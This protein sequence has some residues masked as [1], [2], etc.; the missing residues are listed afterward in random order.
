MATQ[1]KE[2]STALSG[3]TNILVEPGKPEVIVSR[4]FDVPRERLF[5]VMNDPKLLPQWWGP[6]YL[7]TTVDKLEAK[8]GGSWR[9][10][11]QGEDG[12]KHAFHG[13]Y[14]TVT[15]PER[16]VMTFEYE[17]VPDH[18]SLQTI[19]LEDVGGKTLLTEHTVF[20]SVADRDG[21]AQA[22]MEVGIND[23][24]ERLAEL[25]G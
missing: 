6:R 3:K 10:I 7:R 22:G 17:G 11:Q 15:A 9:F 23:S 19:T 5:Q 8:P 16:V 24:M 2:R 4:T 14:H 25:V 20:Q 18:V 21:M 13:V 1:T 12:E